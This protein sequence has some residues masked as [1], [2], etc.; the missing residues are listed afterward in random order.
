MTTTLEIAITPGN[1]VFWALSERIVP[2]DRAAAD[3]NPGR[4]GIG[5]GAYFGAV[6]GHSD[7]PRGAR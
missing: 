6:P 4:A 5:S 1:S 2:Q 7:R 3:P